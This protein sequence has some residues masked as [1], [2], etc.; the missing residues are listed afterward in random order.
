MKLAGLF[1]W[2]CGALGAKTSWDQLM[3]G[4][5]QALA[6]G[7]YLR[8][9]SYFE[10]ALP[11]AANR[12]QE[13]TTLMRLGLVWER[14]EQLARAEEY[15]SRAM[16]V[17]EEATALEHLARVLRKAGRQTEADEKQA[18][19]FAIRA[20]RIAAA[21][22]PAPESEAVPIRQADAAPQLIHRKDPEYSADARLVRQQ[23]TVE[24]SADIGLDGRV[25]NVKLERSLGLGLDEKALEAVEQWRFK[26]AFRGG[27]PVTVRAKVTVH[28]RL[29]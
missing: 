1:V 8:A 16:S 24:F 2:L 5:T 29:L 28:F 23:G 7:S 14:Q 12:S 6:N 4:G 9:E 21:S 22:T 25:H 19:A 13:A 17:G 3:A 11:A 10:M 26:P 15:Y 18:Q 27:R 20:A